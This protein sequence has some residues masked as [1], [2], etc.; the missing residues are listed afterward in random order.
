MNASD[1]PVGPLIVGA[2]L[3]F[4]L[5]AL[6]SAGGAALGRVTRDEA[7]EAE[8]SGARGARRISFL[9]ARRQAAIA[10]LVFLRIV[11]AAFAALFLTLALAGV[12]STWWEAALAFAGILA[13]VTA[14]M[15]VA[16]PTGVGLRR[17]IQTLGLISGPAAA[18]TAIASRT[19]REREASPEESEQVREDQLAVMVERVSQ[20]VVLDEN[21]R[22]LLQSVFDLNHTLVREVMVPRTDMVTIGGDAS[23]DKAMSLF[24]RSGFSRVPVVGETTDDLLGVVYLKD[25]L[26]RTH[27]RADAGGLTVDDLMRDPVF[28]PETKV[29][30]DLMRDMQADQVHI[31]LVGEISDEHDRAVPEVD[32]LADGVFRVPA[33]LP[34]GELGDLF[35]VKLD[36]DDV[37]TVGGL[38]AKLIG[39]VPIAGSTACVGGIHLSAER[40]QGRRRRL[41]TIV[42]RRAHEEGED[43]E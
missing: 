17:P 28:V 4:A 37:D 35:G 31:A 16:S 10:G 34:I 9:V 25:V 29:V 22:E 5:E 42:A 30:D 33:R 8:A 3:S 18:V 12:V 15:A 14:L 43:D 11:F 26:S 6:C 40:F 27:L 1:I 41:A 38:F 13:C 2:V 21:D 19:V 36:D 20:S 39:R 7:V 32:V 23:L 24:T